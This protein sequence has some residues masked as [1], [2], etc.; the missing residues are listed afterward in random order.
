[1][2][3]PTPKSHRI[4][5]VGAGSWGT[6]IGAWLVRNGHHVKIWDINQ[7]IIAEL[8]E[9][10]RNSRFLPDIALPQDLQGSETLMDAVEGCTTVVVAVPSRVFDSVMKSISTCLHLVDQ[11][12]KP[13]VIWGTKGFA[14]ASGELLSDI[15]AR[16]L[17]NRA[18]TATIAG[19]SFA[20]EVIHGIP[21]GF[22]LASNN[23]ED[24]ESIANLF[25]N[26]TSLIYT[27]DDIIGVQVGG[28]TK[29]V[30]AIAAGV[31]DG[32][33]F[34][35]NTRALLISRGFAEMNRLNVAM[36]GRLE[37]LMGLSGM[38]D[39]LLTC[40]GD[41]SRNRRLGL[42]LGRGESLDSVLENIGQEVEGLQSARETYQIGKKLDVFMPMTERV[43]R[44]LYENLPPMQAA[45]EL[46]AI[47]PSLPNR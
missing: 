34:G 40:N 26:A 10:H 35:I 47:G 32:L 15:A 23:S 2:N 43:Y 28:A 16:I 24:I 20:Y 13:V 8:N 17:E 11:A 21:T 27:T 31:S 36:G 42:G 6:A 30:I 41:L 18:V 9:H 25:R 12:A 19:P 7:Q 3:P 45:K 39:L 38:G 4:A 37:T 5:V 46:L 33:G 14:S 1:M 44:I 22:D 29:N